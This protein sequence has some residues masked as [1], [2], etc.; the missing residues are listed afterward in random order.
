MPLLPQVRT[1]E[2][3]Q[4][5]PRDEATYRPAVE[6]IRA[7][8]GLGDGALAKFAGG[9]TIVFSV[10]E[11]HVVKLFEPI[12]AEAAET[13]R[14]VL[15]RV[16]GRL[17]LPTPGV[18]TA[19]ELEGWRYVVME[20]LHGRSL[21]D[22]WDEISPEE[23]EALCAELGRA[24]ARLHE[25]SADGLPLP[26]PDWDAF[27]RGQA[28]TCVERQ[29]AHG[30]G[31][32]WL[33]QIPAFLASVELP[34]GPLVLMHTEIM[35]VHLLARREGAGWALSGLFDFEPAMRGAPE[36]EMASV[37]FFVAGGDGPAFRAFLLGYGY[38]EAELTHDLQRRIL[39]YALLHR[40]SNFRWYLDVLPPK[41]ATTFDALA[42]EWYAFG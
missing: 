7:R 38:R 4:R 11:T 27:L 10:G 28:E 16:H 21:L 39:A 31:E 20:R 26:L 14:A 40:Y 9:S 36:Y 32:A 5:S 41:S 17:G 6:A 42:A 13:E 37:G 15:E 19:G 23:R 18:V 25:V 35:R 22:V 12:F 30:V 8:H 3:F 33:A 2:E 34:R 29:R 1:V 24:V